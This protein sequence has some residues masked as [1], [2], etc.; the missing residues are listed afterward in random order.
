MS[1]YGGFELEGVKPDSDSA[2]TASEREKGK[3]ATP[4]KGSN[5]VNSVCLQM[6]NLKPNARPLFLLRF[7]GRRYAANS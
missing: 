1:L 7:A 4:A 2:T 5:S 6:L 3:S